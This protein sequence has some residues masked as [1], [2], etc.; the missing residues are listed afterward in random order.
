MDTKIVIKNVIGIVIGGLIV[1]GAY[2][3]VT[4][5]INDNNEITQLNTGLTQVV[6]YINQ[7]QPKTSTT[8]TT[9]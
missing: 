1:L 2:F 8:T 4:T 5:V 9:K 7:N 6:N 3:L